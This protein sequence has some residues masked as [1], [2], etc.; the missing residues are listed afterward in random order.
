MATAAI[1][2]K[3]RRD[4]ISHFMRADA[5]SEVNAITYQPERNIQLRH[6]ERLRTNG[7]IRNTAN[8][9]YWIDVPRYDQWSSSRRS[10]VRLAVSALA[11]IG[12]VAAMLT[13]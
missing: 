12:A 10:R 7:V 11:V 5:V 13:T 8:N 1:I 4:V 9:K 6:F 2:A 3:A